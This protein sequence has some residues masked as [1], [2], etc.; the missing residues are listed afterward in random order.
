MYNND[1]K[2]FSDIVH[3]IN[4]IRVKINENNPLFITLK[5]NKISYSQ[6]LKFVPYML[7]FACG[8]PDMVTLIMTNQEDENKQT[9]VDKKINAF[10]TEDNF[11]YNFYL[12][13]LESLG[14]SLDRFGSTSA[15]IRHVFATESIEVRKLIYTLAHYAHQKYNALTRL[16]I[17]EV[18]EAGLYDL[19]TTIYVEIVK[20]ADNMIPEL[21]YYGD[22]HVNLEQNHT[23]TSWFSG[24]EAVASQVS[25]IVVPNQLYFFLKQVIDESMERF[26]AMYHAF[27]RIILSEQEIQPKKYI[28][29]TTPSIDKIT[30]QQSTFAEQKQYS[31]LNLKLAELENHKIFS[32]I[33]NIDRLRMFMEWHVFVVWDFMSLAKRLQ[34]DF[35]STNVPWIPPKNQRFAR[36]INEI[37][38]GE[39]TD[40]LP[41]GSYG[42]HFELYL[43]AMLEINASRN[44]I[45]QFIRDLEA[46]KTISMV[47]EKLSLPGSI[48]QFVINTVNIATHKDTVEVLGSFF[49]GREKIIPNMF[50]SLLNKWAINPETVPMF[51]YYLKRHITLDADHHGPALETIV[52]E[53]TKDAP[54]KK[55]RLLNSAIQSVQKRINLWD[56]LSEILSGI[57]GKS[58]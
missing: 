2:N 48:K 23:V 11:H 40:E 39:E 27:N 7:F 32:L 17:T 18:I 8:C 25:A 37:V 9:E 29:T 46:G 10:I 35:T 28:I 16:T 47:L 33:T 3:Y 5:N 58:K 26:D 51:V 20:K 13:D 50:D 56:S 31:N 54:E 41:D 24:D 22:T 4:Q 38:L 30:Y 14:Y 36:L 12:N 34:N 43:N 1:P 6:R 15:V 53:L 21:Q 52:H 57:Y 45:E 42:S 19:F 49:Y 55:E 44:N